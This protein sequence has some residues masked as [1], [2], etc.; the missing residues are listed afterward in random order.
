MICLV[1]QKRGQGILLNSPFDC[2]VWPDDRPSGYLCGMTA[3]AGVRAFLHRARRLLPHVGVW[4][5]AHALNA[6]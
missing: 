5:L 4:S 6:A 3:V 1:Q 2:A